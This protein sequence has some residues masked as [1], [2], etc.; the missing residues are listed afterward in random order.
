MLY[1]LPQATAITSFPAMA[2]LIH[3]PF[4]TFDDLIHQLNAISDETLDDTT[5]QK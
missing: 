5:Q 4:R 1:A 3:A 2:D